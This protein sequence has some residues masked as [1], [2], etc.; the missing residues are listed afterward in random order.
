MYLRILPEKSYL[1]KDMPD[2][3][4]NLESQISWEPLVKG[5]ASFIT[6]I[7]VMPSAHR[8]EYK[9]SG[10]SILFGLL[11]ILI[12]AVTTSAIF[13]G[14][15]SLGMVIFGLLFVGVGTYVLKSVFTP[16]IFDTQAGYF[17]QGKKKSRNHNAVKLADIYGIQVIKEYIKSS[18]R[19]KDKS[20]YSYEINLVLNTG[21]RLNVVDYGNARSILQDADK[22]AKFINKPILLNPALS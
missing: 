8:L 17:W 10:G 18:S 13:W 14:D 4:H 16:I 5:G 19:G 2:T 12:G 7:L 1:G 15:A 3:Q 11:F 22:I 20:Y 9:P 21:E 6:H